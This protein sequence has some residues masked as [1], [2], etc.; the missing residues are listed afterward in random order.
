M[1]FIF[2]KGLI[3]QN[4]Q[5]MNM[6][7]VLMGW[8]AFLLGAGLFMVVPRPAYLVSHFG[9]NLYLALG[10]YAALAVVMFYGTAKCSNLYGR[11]FSSALGGILIYQ[12]SMT[13]L[14]TNAPWYVIW[15]VIMVGFVLLNNIAY[16]IMG[17]RKQ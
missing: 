1:K 9:L 2:M 17:A 7:Q 10:L 14:T 16:W 11:I 6:S 13:H 15:G 4:M 5:K 8:G 3:M 12:A